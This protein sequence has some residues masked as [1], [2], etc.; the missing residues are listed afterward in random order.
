MSSRASFAHPSSEKSKFSRRAYSRTDHSHRTSFSR[1]NVPFI[2]VPVR[3]KKR[4]GRTSQIQLRAIITRSFTTPLAPYLEQRT[5]RKLGLLQ[6]K[7]SAPSWVE[8]R[9]AVSRSRLGWC[10]TKF[11]K[12]HRHA[13]IN[14]HREAFSFLCVC[15]AGRETVHAPNVRSDCCRQ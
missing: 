7:G 6:E 3:A 14:V 13:T 5:K 9:G 10:E 1:R 15:S 12:R 2:A 8:S 11:F 4:L